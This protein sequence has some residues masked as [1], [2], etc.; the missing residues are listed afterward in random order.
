[1]RVA[2]FLLLLNSRPRVWNTV[3]RFGM[4]PAEFQKLLHDRA[5]YVN[6]KFFL[7]VKVRSQSEGNLLAFRVIDGDLL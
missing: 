3:E 7:N 5:D 4:A 6:K 2:A 1:M